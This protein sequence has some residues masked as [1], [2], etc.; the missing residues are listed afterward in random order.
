MSILVALSILPSQSLL[1]NSKPME[2]NLGQMALDL[3]FLEHSICKSL[4]LLKQK[5]RN[6]K[7]LLV[8]PLI[9]GDLAGEITQTDLYICWLMFLAGEKYPFIR[10]VPIKLTS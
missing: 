5:R 3:T 2:Y 4:L 6:R 8:L 1:L 7:D 9:P 10:N